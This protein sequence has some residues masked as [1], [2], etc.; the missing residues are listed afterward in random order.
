[1]IYFP[2]AYKITAIQYAWPPVFAPIWLPYFLYH[3]TEKATSHSYFLCFLGVSS[4]QVLISAS[5]FSKQLF[6][7]N[8]NNG[9]I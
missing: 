1:M 4:W 7:E 9:F 6:N 5:P 2:W 8:G 3:W